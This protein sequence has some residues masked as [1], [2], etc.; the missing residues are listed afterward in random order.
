M[1][2]YCERDPYAATVLLERMEDERLEPAPVWVGDIAEF[3]YP[4]SVDGIT[5]GIPCQPWSLAGSQQGNDDER[6]LGRE[7]VRIVG[8]LEPEWVFVENVAGFVSWDGIGGL[9]GALSEIGFDAEWSTLRAADVGAPHLRRRVF[10]LAHARSSTV[11]VLP[12]RVPRGRAGE[13]RAEGE[14]E[15]RHDGEEGHV[16]DAHGGGREGGGQPEPGGKRRPRRRVADGCGEVRELEHAE[17]GGGFWSTESDVGRVADGVPNRVDRLRC[18]GN[19]C[20]PQQA[21]A[22]FTDLWSRLT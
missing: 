14:A 2:A 10:I 21:E 7:L 12:E 16:A 4:G 13:L 9:L 18:L 8:E 5:A 11:R 1:V 19:A 3:R 6:H 15:S 17:D 20:V 22:A